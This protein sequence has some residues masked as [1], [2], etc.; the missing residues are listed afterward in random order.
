MYYY[1][2]TNLSSI[3][4]LDNALIILTP[5]ASIPF[6]LQYRLGPLLL[7]L[8]P[9]QRLPLADGDEDENGD[10]TISKHPWNCQLNYESETY[11]DTIKAGHHCLSQIPKI[12]YASNWTDLRKSFLLCLIFQSRSPFT[13]KEWYNI[14]NPVLQI[15]H[16][17]NKLTK[18][19]WGAPPGYL[20]LENPMLSPLTE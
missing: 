9:F 10:S 5:V 18:V 13:E 16:W 8:G 7:P 6:T 14:H 12:F 2:Q 15:I 20:E 1:Q 17:C 11:Y 3:P 19:Q 4:A